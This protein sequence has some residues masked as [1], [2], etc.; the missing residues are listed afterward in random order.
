M[1]EKILDARINFYN[2]DQKCQDPPDEYFEK[3]VEYFLKEKGQN[4]SV[5]KF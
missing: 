4:L 5:S 2:V 3:I 1:E